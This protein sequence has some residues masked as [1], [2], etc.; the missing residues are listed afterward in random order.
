[1]P[2]KILFVT[3]RLAEPSLRR[4]LESMQPADFEE[5]YRRRQAEAPEPAE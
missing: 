3:G 5:I 1:M 2:E 4:V